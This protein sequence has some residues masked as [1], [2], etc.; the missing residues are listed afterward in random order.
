MAITLL[1]I[2]S[3]KTLNMGGSDDTV[4]TKV[5]M[6]EVRQ[7][8]Q[9]TVADPARS[10][11]L[12]TMTGNAEQTLGAL[13]KSF[14]ERSK[15]LGKLSADHSKSAAELTTYMRAWEAEDHARRSRLAG[16]MLAMKA[17]TTAAEW[18]V[19][20]NAYINSVVNQSDRYQSL[21]R[22]EY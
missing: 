7:V 17:Q 18:P 16:V 13:N 20:S 15:E 10:A 5:Q 2:V 19:V 3:C 1:V 21:Q 14:L 6:T 9:T 8:I 4:G 11:A 22:I 12:L